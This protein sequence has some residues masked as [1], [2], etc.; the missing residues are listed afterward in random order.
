MAYAT[1]Q[2]DILSGRLRPGDRLKFPPLCERFG[3]SPSVVR[4]ALNRLADQG[5]VRM[6]PH[7]GFQVTP[8]SVGDLKELVQA[9]VHVET[10]V[11]RLAVE[12]GDLQWE[13]SIVAA[14]HMLARIPEKDLADPARTNPAWDEAHAAFHRTL[15]LGCPNG[16]LLDLALRLRQEFKL[17]R[18]WSDALKDAVDRDAASEHRL[19][20]DAA[21]TR[22]SGLALE[23][24]TAHIVNPADR[25]LRMAAAG[26]LPVA[27]PAGRSTHTSI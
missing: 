20:A 17:Y 9:R 12:H 6:Q 1:L 3:L 24:L 8:L 19:L 22:D 18:H 7:V 16:R 10:E 23:R 27:T 25:L 14:H 4:E 11:F 5:L 26:E 21:V 13:T 15:L 2:S